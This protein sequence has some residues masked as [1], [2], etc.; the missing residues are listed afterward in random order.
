MTTIAIFKQAR[1]DSVNK[2]RKSMTATGIDTVTGRLQ[3]R[4]FNFISDRV[5][6]KAQSHLEKRECALI[7]EVDSG[8]K[9]IDLREDESANKQQPQMPS[10]LARVS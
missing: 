8:T 7:I 2:N 1:I 3:R 6:E 4:T 9:S 5:L 10:N